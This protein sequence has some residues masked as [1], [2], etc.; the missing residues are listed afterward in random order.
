LIPD[1]VVRES[2]RAKHVR[3][4]VSIHEGLEVV[5]P[6]GFDR[7]LIP[8]LLEGK[9]Q[10]IERAMHQVEQHRQTMIAPGQHPAT[11][12]LPTLDQ[13]WQLSWKRTANEDLILA[14]RGPFSLSI[15]GPINDTSA[16]QF[17]LRQW[18]MR[19]ARQSLAPWAHDIA[20]DLGIPV[21]RVTIR[22]QKTRWG[23]YSSNRTMSLNA[24]LLFLPRQL[25]Q[26]VLIH[27]LCHAV[28]LNHSA[29]FWHLV[30]QWE[31]DADRL[32]SELRTAAKHVPSWVRFAKPA[33]GNKRGGEA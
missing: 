13:V 33:A 10:W 19:Q 20:K 25:T 31:P 27:E 14:E 7:G 28:H 6:R 5:I 30:R 18:L 8:A 22:C 32:R 12:E 2:A 4:K 15:S 3:F 23:S 26:Y 9:R 24:Q 11:I 29:Q 17:K 21:Q 1:Y 16:W